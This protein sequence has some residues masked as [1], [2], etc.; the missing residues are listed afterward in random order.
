VAFGPLQPGFWREASSGDTAVGEGISTKGCTEVHLQ[1]IKGQ[2]LFVT[3]SLGTKLTQ[4]L[5]VLQFL[6]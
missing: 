6:Q 1:V 4:N 5:V 3:G 2:T